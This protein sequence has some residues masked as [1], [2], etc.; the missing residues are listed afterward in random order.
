MLTHKKEI[1]K[2]NLV[3]PITPVSFNQATLADDEK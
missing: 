3:T 2:S 1:R